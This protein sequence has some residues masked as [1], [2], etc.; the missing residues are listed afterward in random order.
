VHVVDSS[1]PTYKQDLIEAC[2]ATGAT[3][4]FDATGGGNLATEILES[5]EKALSDGKP[6][7][8]YGS[9]THKQVYL[10]GGLQWGPTILNR[11]YGMQW[12][13]GGWLMTTWYAS[14][15]GDRAAAVKAFLTGINDTF[16]TEYAKRI[17]LEEAATLDVAIDYAKQATG[18]KYLITPN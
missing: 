13:V 5:M 15:K 11:G 9:P 3:L 1:L 2:K 4:A 18:Q 14:G 8:T 17:T 16:K 10:Y 6:H 7:Q 12:G